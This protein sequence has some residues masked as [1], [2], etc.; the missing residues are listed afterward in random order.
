[1]ARSLCFVIR[2]ETLGEEVRT[3]TIYRDR[4][5]NLCVYLYLVS[6]MDT[7]SCV[8]LGWIV[9]GAGPMLI[10]SSRASKV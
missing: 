9:I 6:S 3:D 4:L 5:E 7:T 1:M 10:T 8:L 2:I